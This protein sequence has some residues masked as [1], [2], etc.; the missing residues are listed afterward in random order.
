MLGLDAEILLHDGGMFALAGRHLAFC[1]KPLPAFLAN[2]GPP[3]RRPGR[4]NTAPGAHTDNFEK[5]SSLNRGLCYR[6]ADVEA[7][8]GPRV[9]SISLA[10]LK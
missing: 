6:F 5:G 3:K 9:L 7:R 2:T 8:A 4:P 1:E 10:D